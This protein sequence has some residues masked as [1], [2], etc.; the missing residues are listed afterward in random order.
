MRDN[1][2][3]S[4]LCIGGSMDGA[5]LEAERPIYKTPVLAEKPDLKLIGGETV[6]RAVLTDAEVY[7]HT[8][9]HYVDGKGVEDVGMWLHTDYPTIK[10]AL[11]HMADV[12]S[13]ATKATR[14]K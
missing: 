3:Y 6:A 10:A 1:D 14:R 2:T 8:V 9:F 11:D 12:Y 13:Q 7:T 5:R 4:G